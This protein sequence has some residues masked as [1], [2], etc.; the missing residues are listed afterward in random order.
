MP[1]LTTDDETP[2]N[3]GLL[4]DFKL[5]KIFLFITLFQELFEIFGKGW[6]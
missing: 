1:K 5:L 4:L 2:S 3:P 6:D